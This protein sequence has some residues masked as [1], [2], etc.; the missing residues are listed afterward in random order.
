[1]AMTALG[2]LLPFDSGLLDFSDA[3]IQFLFPAPVSRRALLIHRLIRSQIGLLFGGM[4]VGLTMP[5]AALVWEHIPA[6]DAKAKAL[7]V[8]RP[9]I[10]DFGAAWCGACKELEHY[11]YTNPDVIA[12]SANMI[13]VMVDATDGSDPQVKA[14]LEKYQVRGLPTVKFLKPDG[15]PLE[16]LTV[17]GFLAAEEFLPRMEAALRG[18]G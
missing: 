7:G 4:I 13:P 17:T 8:G 10:V 12:A 18:P 5:S 3:E 14:L 2:W 1:M 16:H 9:L 15:Q 11:T 6:A